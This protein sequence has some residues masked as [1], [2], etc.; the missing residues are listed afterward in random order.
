MPKNLSF[1]AEGGPEFDVTIVSSNAGVESRNLV[2]ELPR[3]AYDIAFNGRTTKDRK[4]LT[5]FFI[6]HCG[7]AYSF[8]YFD[9]LD[10]EVTDD[11]VFLEID[12]S[13]SGGWQLHKVYSF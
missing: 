6:V 11:G 5:A 8:R 9:H 10:H 7:P 4:A 1:G 2:S 3:F 12:G 13:P